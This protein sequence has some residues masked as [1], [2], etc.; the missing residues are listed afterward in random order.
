[1]FPVIGCVLSMHLC[2]WSE[3]PHATVGSVVK[4]GQNILVHFLSGCFL[5]W[6]LDIY[7]DKHCHS[8]LF[9]VVLL[10]SFKFCSFTC[11]G[12]DPVPLISNLGYMLAA[13]SGSLFHLGSDSFSL[14]CFL[15]LDPEDGHALDQ[16][17]KGTSL[18][19]LG[20]LLKHRTI[21]SEFTCICFFVCLFY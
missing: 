10:K 4:G 11:C 19:S 13:A 16:V 20:P 15:H 6:R 3:D 14:L 1:M 8:S 17:Q 9:G 5:G 12:F 2:M 7:N 18:C 21:A